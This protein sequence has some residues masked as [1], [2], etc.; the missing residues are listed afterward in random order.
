MFLEILAVTCLLFAAVPLMMIL[1]NLRLYQAPPNEVSHFNDVTLVSI[2]I[3]ARNE[4]RGIAEAVNAALA[5][6]GVSV[7]VVVLDDHS[8]D[9]TA[10][11]VGELAAIDER[12]RVHDSP[13]LPPGWC[14]KQHACATLAKL[15]RGEVFVYLDADVHVSPNGVA[16]S[17]AFLRQSQA[18]LVSGIPRQVT[19]STSEQMVVPLIHWV[20]LGFLPL[21]RMRKSVHPSYGAGCGQLFVTWAHDYRAVG[22]HAKIRASLHDG[23]KL[24]RAYRAAGLSTDLFDAT[25][26]A[27]CRMYRSGGEVLRGFEKNAIEGLASPRLIV[28][29]TLLLVFGQI[30]PLPLL[31]AA[32]VVPIA[33]WGW[34]TLIASV[35]AAY[36]PRIL[37]AHRFQQPW[38]SVALHP[39]GV[40]LL[41]LIQW[42]ALLK[43]LVGR[44]SQ[45]KDR[46]YET[47]RISA[48]SGV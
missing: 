1:R 12:V 23:V 44:P 31:L 40:A 34:L 29:A 3:P 4:E 6:E 18:S 7:E 13:P 32:F 38:L 41:L 24:P 30:L 25:E 11:I 47:K 48:D 28:P 16:R 20:L 2:L 26:I 15:A 43:W 39:L 27:T 46:G 21:G 17:V 35:F 36:A 8:T 10:S 19:E 42:S 45:W 22:G 9:R 5:S 33:A 14:G 37:S